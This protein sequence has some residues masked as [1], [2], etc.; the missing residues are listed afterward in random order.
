VTRTLGFHDENQGKTNK[1]EDTQS[2]NTY[3]PHRLTV[4]TLGSHP[5]NRSS[6]LREVMMAHEKILYLKYRIFSCSKQTIL[7]TGHHDR[8]R[9]VFTIPNV[10]TVES[11]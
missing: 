1:K 8:R 5:R 7:L 4:R 3:R 10:K 2:N 9:H 11:G 6:I